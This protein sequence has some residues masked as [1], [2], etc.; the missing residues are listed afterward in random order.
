MSEEVQQEA[1]PEAVVEL[2]EHVDI[3]EEVKQDHEK[4]S[5]EEV[6]SGESK[7]DLDAFEKY[8]S[9][10]G[11]DPSGKKS[12]LDWMSY[13]ERKNLNIIKANQQTIQLLTS[14]IAEK[15]QTNYKQYLTQLDELMDEAVQVGNA[16]AYK[17][18][19]AKYKELSDQAAEQVNDYQKTVVTDRDVAVRE[20]ADRNKELL[21]DKK[22]YDWTQSK[23]SQLYAT[24]PGLSAEEILDLTEKELHAVHKPASSSA[25]PKT[26]PISRTGSSK[27]EITEDALY[28]ENLTTFK[29]LQK[30]D[31]KYTIKAFVS[32]M[33]KVNSTFKIRGE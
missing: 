5:T 13:W 15:E 18:Y 32:D 28:P 22:I 26:L 31:P 17:T 29:F 9:T 23:L 11:W 24:L 16:E 33:K 27:K 25:I 14:K 2:P 1:A 21:A 6:V 3:V 12:A 30:R 4:E 10:K 20:F 8:A 19:K 7:K